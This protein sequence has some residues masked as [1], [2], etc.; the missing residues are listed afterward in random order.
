MAAANYYETLGVKK[1]ASIDD[2]KKAFR[3]LAR[4]HH[5]DAGGDEEKF[6]DINEAYEVLGDP[7]KRR[8][9]DELGANWQSGA[10]F[11]PPHGWESFGRGRAAG[12]RGAGAGAHEF[13]FGGT[14][15]S[16]F[17]EQLFGR[18]GRGGGGFGRQGGGFPHEGGPSSCR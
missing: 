6:K 14:G 11:R 10:D 13:H 2:I 18:A 7:A 4:K 12:G 16:D 17:F 9:Y 5:P 3:R 1:D 15:F 8:R